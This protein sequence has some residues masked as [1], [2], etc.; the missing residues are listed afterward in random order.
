[1]FLF[2]V[3][4][5]TELMLFVLNNQITKAGRGLR[6]CAL[7]VTFFFNQLEVIKEKVLFKTNY[8]RNSRRWTDELLDGSSMCRD[9]GPAA[10]VPLEEVTKGVLVD[11]PIQ[12]VSAGW[13]LLCPKPSDD[14]PHCQNQTVQFVLLIAILYIQAIKFLDLSLHSHWVSFPCV[15]LYHRFKYWLIWV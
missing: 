11:L 2:V 5:L 7:N 13:W 15:C 8:N 12:C 4:V 14:I 10:S 3:D 1:M 6:T 9:G